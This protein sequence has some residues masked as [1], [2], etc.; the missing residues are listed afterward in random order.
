M[1]MSH[2]FVRHPRWRTLHFGTRKLN[3][4]ALLSSGY[5]HVQRCVD[6]NDAVLL[7]G[8]A[9]LIARRARGT[10]GPVKANVEAKGE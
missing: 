2:D 9:M 6:G 4:G 7:P 1:T 3:A 5:T 10:G 8:L